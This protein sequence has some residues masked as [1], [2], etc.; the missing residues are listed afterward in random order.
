MF[1]SMNAALLLGI[2]R[3]LRGTQRG[4]WQRTARTANA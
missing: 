4:I 3:W 1:V 2:V